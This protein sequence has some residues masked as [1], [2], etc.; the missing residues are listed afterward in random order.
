MDGVSPTDGTPSTWSVKGLLNISGTFQPPA[1]GGPALLSITNGAVV[2]VYRVGSAA[3]WIWVGP[4]GTVTGN[5]TLQGTSDGSFIPLTF[6]KGTIEPKG[7]TLTIDS[8]LQLDPTA[9]TVCNVSPSG[10]DNVEVTRQALLEGRLMVTMT[11]DFSSAPNRYTLLHADQGL[12]E[13]TFRSESI[14]YPTGQGWHPQVTYD[15]ANGYVY[16]DRIYDMNP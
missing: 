12:S 9:T 2:T 6:V 3:L 14:T 5:G 16:L 15:S 11:G 1:D 8:K 13:T 10:A 4:S 7:G